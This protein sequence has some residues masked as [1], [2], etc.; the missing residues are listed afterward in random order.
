MQN[1]KTQVG[2]VCGQRGFALLRIVFVQRSTLWPI[3]AL[4]VTEVTCGCCRHSDYQYSMSH[5]KKKGSLCDSFVCLFSIIMKFCLPFKNI[6][7]REMHKTNPK[8]LEKFNRA[9]HRDFKIMLVKSQ[10]HLSNLI[11]AH[12]QNHSIFVSS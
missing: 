10:Q 12:L 7:T 3:A 9:W 8:G 6:F 5:V 1:K 4:P 11:L 2:F